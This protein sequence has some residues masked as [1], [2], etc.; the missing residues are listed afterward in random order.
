VVSAI[1]KV[2]E[3][4]PIKSRDAFSVFNL[5]TGVETSINDISFELKETCKE[6]N[7]ELAS[8]I[9]H[10]EAAPGEQRRSLLDAGLFSETY[11]WKPQI[12]IKEGLKQTLQSFSK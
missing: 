2:I 10:R 7:P 6:G 3:D 8:K 4:Q 9:V 12:D 1:A 5:G 11:G